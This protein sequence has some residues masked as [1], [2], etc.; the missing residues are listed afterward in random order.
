MRKSTLL[1]TLAAIPVLFGLEPEKTR[2]QAEYHQSYPM[3]P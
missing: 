3:Q 2:V 1:L